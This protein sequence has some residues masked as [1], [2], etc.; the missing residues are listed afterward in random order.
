MSSYAIDG[1][2]VKDPIMLIW[3]ERFSN[4]RD[5]FG[6]YIVSAYRS[7]LASFNTITGAEL[8]D[9]MDACDEQPHTITMPSEVATSYTYTTFSNV[10]IEYVS[11]NFSF[12]VKVYAAQFRI[13]H[14]TTTGLP[15]FGAI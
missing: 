6:R 3:D 10:Y 12:G 15:V 2:T 11:D 5:F 7:A 13:R 14:I 1:S 8:Q 9:W 4:G